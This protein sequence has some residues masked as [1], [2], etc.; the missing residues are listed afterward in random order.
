MFLY[1]SAGFAITVSTA[2]RLGV[3]RKVS[4]VQNAFKSD[5]VFAAQCYGSEALEDTHR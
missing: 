1:R 2:C 3:Y 4:D 5:P